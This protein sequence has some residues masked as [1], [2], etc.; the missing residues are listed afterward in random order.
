MSLK[1]TIMTCFYTNNKRKLYPK[2]QTFNHIDNNILIK[3]IQSMYKGAEV[4][5]TQYF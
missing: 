2:T 1:F 4:K 5:W 3:L